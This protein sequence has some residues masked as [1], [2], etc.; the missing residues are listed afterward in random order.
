LV[1]VQIAQFGDD[2]GK[3]LTLLSV[4]RTAAQQSR[5]VESSEAFCSVNHGEQP[6]QDLSHFRVGRLREPIASGATP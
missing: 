5:F 4:F 6:P 3:L 2:P 1:N